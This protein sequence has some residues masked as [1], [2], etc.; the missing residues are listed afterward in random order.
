MFK[1]YKI[2]EDRELI[3]FVNLHGYITLQ[4]FFLPYSL[5]E[6]DED[7]VE[8]LD[9]IG[10]GSFSQRCQSKGSDRSNLLLLID[11]SILNDLHQ[12]LQ[13]RQN[14]TAHQDGYLLDD[15]DARVTSLPG[16]LGTTDS[17]QEGKERGDAE[18]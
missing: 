6:S 16:L 2:Y 1:E 13:V 9:T 14:S 8:S 12:A 7:R 3:I 4:V 10:S 5:P 18:G 11:Q 17:L 15:L